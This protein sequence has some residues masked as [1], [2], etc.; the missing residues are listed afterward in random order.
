MSFIC[1]VDKTG[2][3]Q[4]GQRE[5]CDPVSKR[6]D[7]LDTASRICPRL[8][9]FGWITAALGNRLTSFPNFQTSRPPAQRGTPWLVGRFPSRAHLEQVEMQRFASSPQRSWK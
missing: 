8:A 3:G 4:Q 9:G 7:F 2:L 5:T 6:Q 1:I